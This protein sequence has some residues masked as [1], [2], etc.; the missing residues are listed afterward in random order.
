MTIAERKERLEIVQKT[1]AEYREARS[2]ILKGGQSYTLSDQ[3]MQRTVTNASL[4]QINEQIA[5]LEAEERALQSAIS[6]GRP[7]G[8]YRVV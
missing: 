5:K 6:S 4:S 8:V 2:F 3:N 1:L 7:R